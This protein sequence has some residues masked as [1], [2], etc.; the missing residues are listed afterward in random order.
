MTADEPANWRDMPLFDSLS[1]PSLDGQWLHPR[2]NGRNGFAEVAGSMAVAQVRWA[3]AV[4]MGST[5]GYDANRYVD[6]CRAVHQVRLLP[7]ILVDS[8]VLTS[9]VL[10]DDWLG[11]VRARDFVGIKLHPRL[12][13]FD[14]ANPMLPYLIGTANRTGLA[15]MLC[16]YCYSADPSLVDL[17][18]EGLRRLL[19]SIPDE[20]LLLLHGAT[21]RLLELAELTRCFRRCLLDVSWTVCEY[22]GTS[23]DRD[24]RYVLDRCRDRVCVGSDSPEFTPVQLRRRLVALTRG[25]TSDHVA[26][27]A[28]GNLLAFSQAALEASTP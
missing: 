9:R 25:F 12:G 1:H 28:H 6:A 21:V 7:A 18:V 26:R 22:A 27:I 14:F 24:L 5:E 16:T 3:W 20:P 4:A 23:L 17:S 19:V 13:R 15:V 10:C 2:W 11:Q 8:T